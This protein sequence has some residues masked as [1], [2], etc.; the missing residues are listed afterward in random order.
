VPGDLGPEGAG[1]AG[2]GRAGK[3]NRR[4][5]V[6]YAA[7]EEAQHLRAVFL[8]YAE[9]QEHQRLSGRRANTDE[10]RVDSA[11]PADRVA[12]DF[13]D[14]G[15]LKRMT[16]G[17]ATI[18]RR[19]PEL[20]QCIYGG[21]KFD[22]PFTGT[23]RRDFVLLLDRRVGGLELFRR[24]KERISTPPME[25]ISVK[26]CGAARDAHDAWADESRDG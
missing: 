25:H 11:A 20:R 12:P 24:Q 14:I 19:R 18:E 2:K 13:Q 7:I 21:R 8:A 17:G 15:A 3:Q 6:A 4:V 5:V 16:F 26:E 22:P 1:I 9:R 10:Q 23:K